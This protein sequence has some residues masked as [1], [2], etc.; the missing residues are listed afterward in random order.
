MFGISEVSQEG[1]GRQYEG[2]HQDCYAHAVKP[3]GEAG[4]MVKQCPDNDGSGQGGEAAGEEVEAQGWPEVSEQAPQVEDGAGAVTPIG[5]T[6]HSGADQLS[7]HVVKIST[8]VCSLKRNYQADFG[9]FFI[10]RFRL[11]SSF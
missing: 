4:A 3:Q 5:Q 7:G 10:H 11:I 6:E 8:Q 9:Y 1:R 2:G